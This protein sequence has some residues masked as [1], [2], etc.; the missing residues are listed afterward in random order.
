MKDYQ[1]IR[2]VITQYIPRNGAIILYPGC[3]MSRVP[4]LMYNEG[5]KFI[6]SI[7]SSRQCITHMKSQ[8]PK[9]PST[10]QYLNM[11]ALEMD[12]AGDVFT[13]VIDKG[14]L[15]SIFLSIKSKR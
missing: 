1:G 10:F 2:D 8:Y 12:F 13:T 5:Y 4:E 6:I 15:D 14:L 9:M 3:G 7:D 11:D